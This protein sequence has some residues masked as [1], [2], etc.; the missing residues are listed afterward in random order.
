MERMEDAVA[1]NRDNPDFQRHLWAA[2]QGLQLAGR[3]AGKAAERVVPFP[4]EAA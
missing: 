1:L 2:L 4:S 3:R